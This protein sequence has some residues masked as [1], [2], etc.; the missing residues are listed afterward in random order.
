M[1]A[2]VVFHG[3][4]DGII[5]AY[6][7]IKRFY[8]DLYPHGL[9]L[10][11]THP[12][13]A[14]IDITRS[15]SGVEELVI[16]DIA[17]SEKLVDTLRS[18]SSKCKKIVYIDHHESS[19]SLIPKIEPYAKVIYAQVSSTPRLLTQFMGTPLNPY[20][21]V[22]VEVADICE[23][24]TPTSST[25]R[26]ILEIVDSVRM[27]VAVNPGDLDFMK[28]LIDLMVK[29]RNIPQ[30]P[31]VRMR[32]R[33]AKF[34]LNSLLKVLSEDSLD[35]GRIKMSFLD[36]PMSRAFAGI[37]GVAATELSKAYRKGIVL[38]REEQDK[39]VIT[40]RSARRDALELSKQIASSLKGVYGGHAEASSITI[41]K[42]PVGSVVSKILSTVL[43]VESTS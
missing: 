7:Y 39:V 15:V 4:C 17:L 11:V 19:S 32:V 22:L 31:L 38:I 37:I 24:R 41:P 28:Y 18:I 26:S 10:V 42:E 30:D 2:S 29:A 12:W 36:L 5:A 3:D 27:S 6:L 21:N 43:G 16:V 14:H 33:R 9:N 1:K 34:L 8:R 13:R 25:D 23:G 35:V 20:E 40:V